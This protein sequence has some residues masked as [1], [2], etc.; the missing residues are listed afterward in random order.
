MRAWLRRRA[1]GDRLTRAQ[2]EDLVAQILEECNPKQRAY[3]ND[4][5]RRFAALT[6]ARAGKTTASKARLVIKALRIRR[7]RLL[8]IAVTKDQAGDLMWGPLKDLCSRLGIKVIPNETKLQLYFP[9]TGSFIRILGADDKAEIEKLRGRPWHEVIIDEAASH[10]HRLLVTLI[11]KVIGPRLGDFDGVLG[12]I[13][14]PGHVLHGLFYDATRRGSTDGLLWEERDQVPED[15]R[16]EWSVHKWTLEYSAQFTVVQATAWRVAL[17]TK[18]KKGWTD[19]NPTWRREYL[20]EWCADEGE[21][22]YAYRPHVDEFLREL[23][24]TTLEIGAPWNLWSPARD[25]DGWAVLPK[26]FTDWR[27]AVGMDLG[28]GVSFALQVLGYSPSDKERNFYQ[29]YEVVRRGMYAR[30]IAQLILGEALDHKNPGG[31]VGK[32]GCWPDI[33]VCDVSN[34]GG[35][36]IDELKDV[37]GIHIVPADQRSK[38]GNVELTNG[39]L[40]D[41]RAHLLEGSELVGEMAGLQW[42]IDDFGLP[43]E[44]KHGDNACDGFIYARGAVAAM[45]EA[46]RPPPVAAVPRREDNPALDED[47]DFTRN[48]KD[49]FMSSDYYDEAGN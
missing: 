43:R 44:P 29:R 5:T 25:K 46:E 12:M 49:A 18:G 4:P 40:I 28:H 34:L 30:K 31:I 26:K 37:Y 17:Y 3:V 6:S 16:P 8:F 35:A 19:A 13:G 27:H 33:I 2:V 1:G 39:D 47:R 38:P 45:F 11:E 32:L 20:G 9:Q 22:M 7:A 41:G 36:I 10:P 21:M 48:R 24:A 14:T 42:R 15:K 23:H